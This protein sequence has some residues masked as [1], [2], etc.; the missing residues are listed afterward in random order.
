MKQEQTQSPSQVPIESLPLS[1]HEFRALA[2]RSALRWWPSLAAEADQKQLVV[3]A[4]T[5]SEIFASAIDL[6][7]A[8]VLAGLVEGL[9]HA[10]PSEIIRDLV[11]QRTDGNITTLLRIIT[12]YGEVDIRGQE[13]TADHMHLLRLK[14]RDPRAKA[15]ALIERP[16]WNQAAPPGWTE[17]YARLMQ[18]MREAEF[19]FHAAAF[20][21]AAVLG[22][23]TRWR[24]VWPELGIEVSGRRPPG[25]KRARADAPPPSSTPAATQ[26]GDIASW[27]VSDEAVARREA[28]LLS[29]SSYAASI[30][31]M[32]TDTRTGTPLTFAINGPWGCGKTSLAR[33]IQE[34]LQATVAEGGGI[35]HITC[36]FNA[37][38]HD[39]AA[40]MAA[41]FSSAIAQEADQQRGR[42]KRF[43]NPVPSELLSE[44]QRTRRRIW[45]GGIIMFALAA[46]TAFIVLYPGSGFTLKWQDADPA[47]TFALFAAFATLLLQL[48]RELAAAAKTVGEFVLN[49]K[50]VAQRGSIR[51][52]RD[53][54][55]ELISSATKGRR[56]F[57][58]FVDD[59]ERCK[60]PRA[61]DLLE[62]VNQLL[63]HKDVVTIV[64]ADLPAVAAAAEI[65]YQDLV[66]IYAANG[67][68]D[69]VTS[70]SY[71]RMYLQKI[72]QLEF[73]MPSY[74][75]ARIR[76]F[77]EAVTRLRHEEAV[78]VEPGE[79]LQLL[80]RAINQWGKAFWS[81]MRN[82]T[83]AT[84]RS[85]WRELLLWSSYR[86]VWIGTAVIAIVA[87]ILI[88][89][90]LHTWWFWLII[91]LSINSAY[92]TQDE[93]KT[94]IEAERAARLRA[95][96]DE[97]ITA[98]TQ[99]LG[100][101][102][103]IAQQLGAT[104]SEAER[105]A[106]ERLI[107]NVTDTDSEVWRVSLAVAMSYA[108]RMPRHVK[109]LTNRLRLLLGLAQDCGILT[110]DITTIAASVGKWAALW[111]RWPEVAHEVLKD[112]G[113]MA[114]LE[115]AAAGRANKPFFDRV[116]VYA[117][118]YAGDAALK[119]FCKSAPALAPLIASIVYLEQPNTKGA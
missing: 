5:Y 37:W 14:T 54:L 66:K 60:P 36:W 7:R 38:M 62:V 9:P 73:N 28:D 86:Y 72:I 32:I 91:L 3:I 64:I 69:G 19:S 97:S 108:P 39:D 82:T 17:M 12:R 111:E 50:A 118:H 24:A 33:L 20:F 83:V 90:P 48:M 44:K 30:A 8:S 1:D 107:R 56:R 6:A 55:E 77:G 31:A 93:I 29:F 88:E 104:E 119:A 115:K 74:P 16:L 103:E 58:I 85:V 96:V 76:K 63:S 87:V 52:V 102:S 15:S 27:M 26:L 68:R 95:G 51:E 75:E 113:H 43:F 106:R 41:A 79:R 34:N 105:F 35:K 98:G 101:L 13:L 47:S 78:K 11:M 40:D 67:N 92:Q 112:P 21:E 70:R 2:A 49:P 84:A 22:G 23:K 18:I 4:D 71:G 81:D 114:A 110:G 57:I 99:D 116:T 10:M 59:V 25:S 46:I 61:V 45:R 94:K 100:Q 117:P 53:Q 42:I 89:S 80:L 65:K 109:R